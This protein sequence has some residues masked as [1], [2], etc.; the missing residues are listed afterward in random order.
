MLSFGG[1]SPQLYYMLLLVCSKAADCASRRAAEIVRVRGKM[2]VLMINDI[3]SP[4]Y[5]S[6][7]WL[8]AASILP[9][10]PV[11]TGQTMGIPPNRGDL[12]HST[13]RGR[14]RSSCRS[15]CPKKCLWV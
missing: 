2:S 6:T 9:S 11:L 12:S 7:E 14:K 8:L 10:L 4:D 1:A 3:V 5:L 13:I 15:W